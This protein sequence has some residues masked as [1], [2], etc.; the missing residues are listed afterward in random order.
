[1]AGV[2]LEWVDDSCWFVE[3]D[4][5]FLVGGVLADVGGGCEK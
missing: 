4:V 3:G 1:M 5:A 2:S